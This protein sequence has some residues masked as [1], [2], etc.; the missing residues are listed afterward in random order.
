VAEVPRGR[1]LAGAVL[2][3][4]VWSAAACAQAPADAARG[5]RRTELQR[6]DVPGSPFEAVIGLVEVPPGLSIGRHAHPGIEAGYMLDGEATVSLDGEPDRVLKAGDAYRIPYGA[7]HDVRSGPGGA[8]SVAV[9]V[10][11]KGKP[12]ATPAR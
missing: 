11:E 12:L 5:I 6:F 3:G 1:V 2:I 9:F 8:R 10:V 7:V 4:L